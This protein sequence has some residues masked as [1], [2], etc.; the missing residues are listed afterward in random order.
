MEATIPQLFGPITAAHQIYSRKSTYDI[1][2]EGGIDIDL[3]RDEP[4]IEIDVQMEPT[5]DKGSNEEREFITAGESAPLEKCCMFRDHDFLDDDTLGRVRD[6][7]HSGAFI[8]NSWVEAWGKHC[9]FH[10]DPDDA[11]VELLLQNGG[12]PTEGVFRINSEYPEDG[13]WWDSQLR[14]IPALPGGHHFLEHYAHAVAELDALRI[15]RGGL[16]LEKAHTEHIRRFA[17]AYTA[18]PARKF[19][20]VDGITDPVVVRKLTESGSTYIYAVNREYYPISVEIDMGSGGGD[21]TDLATGDKID[22]SS[23]LNMVLKPYELRSFRA[24]GVVYVVGF[25]STPPE[26]IVRDVRQRAEASLNAMCRVAQAGM[27]IPGMDRMREGIESALA[28]GRVAWLRRALGSYIVR[29][30]HQ[31]DK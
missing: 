27:S 11:N 19:E 13:F 16:F 25:I 23:K 26:A 9:W 6:L 7:R 4:G 17:L 21:L 18:L 29:K 30:C 14:I 3:Y 10:A 2:R 8:F 12:T 28:E 15:T 22:V 1:Y 31:I 24:E 20:D 5:R